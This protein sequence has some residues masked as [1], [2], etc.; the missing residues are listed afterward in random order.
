VGVECRWGRSTNCWL[1]IVECRSVR[2]TSATVCHAVYRTDGD[3]SESIFVTA[4]SV[5]DHNEKNR[6]Y[7]YTAVNL[8]RNLRS[9]YCTIE[10]LTDTEHHAFSTTAKLLAWFS[11]LRQLF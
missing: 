5:D 6:I 10:A 7:L 8:K 9:V 11:D 2:S 3:A 1:S 4:C